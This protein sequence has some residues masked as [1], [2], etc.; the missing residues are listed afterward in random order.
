MNTLPTAWL[1]SVLGSSRLVYDA[2]EISTGREGYDSYRSL[3]GWVEKHLM[4]RAAGT[5]TTTDTRAKF[6]SRAYGV[7]RPVVL[8]NRPKYTKISESDRIR[9]ELELAE[10]WPIFLYQGG[11]QQ[12]RGLE[13]LI[14]AAREVENTYFVFIGWGR[15]ELSMKNLVKKLG[16]S[17]RI[18]FIPVV[19]LSDLPEY[20]A[21]ADVCVHPLENTCI[22][23]WSTDSN[24]LFEYIQAGCP[25]VFS[26]FPEIRKIVR[27]YG[28]GLLIEPGDKDSLVEALTSLRTD[29]ALRKRCRENAYIA[30]KSL[31]WEEQESK[32][33]DLY[34][35]VLARKK[36]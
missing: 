16:L 14:E 20:T 35:E 22:N 29:Q 5:I 13:L 34:Q 32:L 27:K 25:I 15:L 28:L 2:H 1:A 24:K 9:R 26:D 10:P 18:R 33:T 19:P 6:F 8:Q 12:G 11:F 7:P 17:D 3:V 36:Y 4:P 30:A 21:S 23:H 31:T